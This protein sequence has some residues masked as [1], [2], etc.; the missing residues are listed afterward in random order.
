[1]NSLLKPKKI[2]SIVLISSWALLVLF[3]NG[4]VL[5]QTVDNLKD[6]KSDLQAKIEAINKQISKYQSEISKTR[7]QQASLSNEIK[8]YDTQIKSTELALEA[9]E[10]Q[11]ADTNLQIDELQAQIQRRFKEISDNK[12]ILSELVNDL[13]RQDHSS[14]LN[15]TIASTDFSDFLDQVQYT[16][17]VQGKVYQ[18]VQSIKDI[19]AKLEAQQTTLKKELTQLEQLKEQLE[20]TKSSLDVQKVQKQSLLDKTRGIEKNYQK[21][22]S[23]SKNEEA[24]LQKEVDDLDN[25]IRQKLGQRTLQPSKGVLAWPMEGTITQRYGKT[26]FTALGY[27]S[28]NG[29]D[30]AAP[31]GTPIYAAGDGVVVGADTGQAAYG[32][33]VAI[34]HSVETKQGTV[35]QIVALYAHMRTFKVKM[36]QKVLQGD[37]IGYEGNTGNT[38]RLLYGPERGYHLHFTIFDAEGFG[39]STGK[40]SKTYGSYS[41]PYGYTYNPLDFL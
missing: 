28:H 18:L 38:T 21:L 10:T 2:L 15:T 22:L 36:G 27:N 9:K 34:K 24:D 32:N 14:W 33:W 35:R 26:G 29:I 23:A 41:V 8:I 6:K 39:I 12:V 25:S 5:A 20:V 17:S 13:Y 16:Q 30:L 7:G 31:A 3:S 37:L 40:Y 1:M 11:I 19:K 4:F